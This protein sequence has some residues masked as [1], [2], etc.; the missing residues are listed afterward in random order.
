MTFYK[1]TLSAILSSLFQLLFAQQNVKPIN[2]WSFNTSN[3]LADSIENKNPLKVTGEVSYQ[4]GLVGKAINLYESNA[5][6]T[7]KSLLTD[8]SGMTNTLS[9]AFVYQLEMTPANLSSI[10]LITN[11]SFQIVL[12]PQAI[13]FTTFHKDK[14]R[15]TWDIPLNGN[16]R[17]NLNYFL[18]HHFHHWVF[19][20]D[21]KKGEK[22]LWID[23]LKV[24]EETTAKE[25]KTALVAEGITYFQATQEDRRNHGKWDEIAFYN[26]ILSPNLIRKQWIEAQQGKP[27][28]FVETGTFAENHAGIHKSMVAQRYDI[29][30]F[31]PGHP[32]VNIPAMTQLQSY[33]APRFKP[34]HQ[35]HRNVDW[36]S[37]RY[38]DKTTPNE[39]V[40]ALW[41]ELAK[42]WNYYLTVVQ[43]V[44]FAP[45]KGQIQQANDNPWFPLM[46]SSYWGFV[47]QRDKNQMGEKVPYIKSVNL[48]SSHYLMDKNGKLLT[49]QKVWSPA[50]PLDS[51]QKD[52]RLQRSYFEKYIAPELKRPI[53]F[54]G[55]NGEV[56]EHPYKD[57]LLMQDPNV[58]KDKQKHLPKV[59]WYTY[60]SYRRYQADST[61]KAEFMKHPLLKNAEYFYYEIEGERLGTRY[62]Y[63]QMRKIHTPLR[64]TYYATH[65]FYPVPH[66]LWASTSGWRNGWYYTMQARSIELS[67][68][69]KWFCPFI[70]TGFSANEEENMRPARWL[71][72]TKALAVTGAEFYHNFFYTG[73]ETSQAKNYI[74]NAVIPAY[75]Q[76]IT[77]HYMDIFLQGSVLEGDM[78]NPED[79]FK[80]PIYRFWTGNPN[81]LV[82]VRKHDSKEK[83][84]I[85][86]SIQPLQ[87]NPTAAPR[88][89]T[90]SI[91]LNGETLTFEIRQQGS[92]Y[93]YDKSNGKPVF[94]QLDKWHQYEHPAWW[95]KDIAIQAEVMDS[96]AGGI[97]KIYT[98]CPSK[99]VAGDYSTY[100]SYIAANNGTKIAYFFQARNIP[101]HRQ[102]S[103]KVR[104]RV[105]DG[106][107]AN[108]GMVFDANSLDYKQPNVYT[109]KKA[110]S[111][112]MTIS[113][114]EWKWY[115][116]DSK[117][118][119]PII[120]KGFQAD[121][122]QTL[123]LSPASDKIEIDEIVLDASE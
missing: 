117:T 98:E 105:K 74:W 118:K 112:E 121:T 26:T 83:Y 123:W 10:N 3:P 115:N 75:T 67:L 76:A 54:I 109:G 79:Y 104:A 92:T 60:Q 66:A 48:P 47:N 68:G 40:L 96:V 4:K 70:T 32:N 20:F 14:N 84:V 73:K 2:Y 13:R 59:D 107:N 86:G 21:S 93:I 106:G 114:S 22:E 6:T 42:N 16:E 103:L 100:T 108:L 39:E 45:A 5:M 38:A 37:M 49:S 46:I 89:D 41:I 25:L 95:S 122:P 91:S 31:A 8:A 101:E 113:G 51:I 80:T 52:G 7:T 29:K 81:H 57:S 23:G 82:V 35:L 27:F 28:N 99:A 65:S 11:N 111:N 110:Q 19:I 120:F 87:L 18:D 77:S 62:K 1:I 69:D 36:F 61:Y 17:Q 72:L 33:P 15:H 97:A 63:E 12:L 102:F 116:V 30:A 90:V 55:E 78:K 88:I 24:A 119:S 64:N 34:F 94:Y 44:A 43:N 56:F 53:D 50:S 85:T 9:V 58:V 71:G